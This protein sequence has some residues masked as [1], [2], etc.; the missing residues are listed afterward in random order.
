MSYQPTSAL[1]TERARLIS[2]LETQTKTVSDVISFPDKT[3]LG[4][5]DYE[6]S[7]LIKHG[8]QRGYNLALEAVKNLI[9]NKE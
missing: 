1:A 2:F 3:R 5:V 7:C 9:N 8:E 4:N 6:M